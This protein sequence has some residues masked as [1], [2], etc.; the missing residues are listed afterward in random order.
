MSIL[1]NYWSLP[2]L[3]ILHDFEEMIV[4]PLW[5]KRSRFRALKNPTAYFGATRDGSAFSVG[6]L[7]EFVILLLIS[8]ICQ[9]TGNNRLY[10]GFCIAYALHFL[11][12]YK[13]S[14]SFRGYVPGLVTVT[15]QIPLM[16]LLIQHY[17]V[18][19]MSSLLYILVAM[20][21]SYTNL[22]VLHRLMP[23]IEVIFHRYA[24]H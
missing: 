4:M 24:S 19:D 17:L 2:I 11:I 12:H 7:E 1:L 3:F 8:A 18:L 20:I 16:Y 15:L 22:Y 14:Y 5:K 9:L 6:V 10:L 21:I 13:L 23:K